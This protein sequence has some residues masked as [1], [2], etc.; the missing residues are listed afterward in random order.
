V[1]A[2]RGGGA[3]GRP[4]RQT[5]AACAWGECIHMSLLLRH[6]LSRAHRSSQRHF[7]SRGPKTRSSTRA[8]SITAHNTRQ[9]TR[10]ASY[11]RLTIHTTRSPLPRRRRP[12][13]VRSV[14]LCLLARSIASLGRRHPMSKCYEPPSRARTE[15]GTLPEMGAADADA[16]A[17]GTDT[18]CAMLPMT[19]NV[20]A[21]TVC[22]RLRQLPRPPPPR[23]SPAP[24]SLPP[25]P[26]P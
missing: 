23:P 1:A 22:D 10:R 8:C 12:L 21:G 24:H 25:P 6:V 13:L 20:C 26:S 4:F 11:R 5:A 15:A 19:T 17:V 14:A 16:P 18:L 2:C 9:R 3:A 7:L